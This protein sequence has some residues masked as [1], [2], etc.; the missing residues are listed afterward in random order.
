M[1]ANPYPNSFTRLRDFL[2]IFL[3]SLIPSRKLLEKFRAQ[4]GKPGN[5]EEGHPERWF[6]LNPP[7]AAHVDQKTWDD[8]EFPKIFRLID[9]TASPIGAQVLHRQLREYLDDPAD[10]DQRHRIHQQLRDDPALRERLYHCLAPITDASHAWVVDTLY[11]KV[12]EPPKHRMAISLWGAASLLVMVVT[13]TGLL[14][15][16]LWLAMIP[17]NL[18][19]LYHYSRPRLHEIETINGCMHLMDAAEKLCATAG[20]LPLQTQ[21]RNEAGAR[22]QIR[23]AQRYRR[24]IHWIPEFMSPWLNLLFLLEL[25]VHLWSMQRFYQVRQHLRRSFELVG[26]IDAAISMASALAMFPQHCQPKIGNAMELEVIDGRHPL[27]SEGVANSLSLADRSALIIGSNMAGKTT[28]IKMLAINAILG[29]TQGFCLAHQATLPATPVMAVIHGDHS[30]ESG[31][32]RYFAEIEA[33]RGFLQSSSRH[34]G[35]LF[36]IDEPFSGTNTAERIA[37]SCAVLQSLARNSLVLVTSHDVELQ[38]MLE[39]DY[40]LFHFQE[41]PD[42][43]GYFDYRLRPGAA[44]ERNA[45]RL[46]ARV[47]FP[48]EVVQSAREGMTQ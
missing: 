5:K 27:L 34:A 32:S 30:V 15:P 28:F 38:D 41:N 48:N 11:A 29:R 25:I 23:R 43:E 3:D 36:V 44:T 6:K 24:L 10:L 45:I 40:S 2:G 31:K 1:A 39:A 33:I 17:V 18:I 4:W 35:G 14:Q 7:E 12:P 46:L 8:L 19:V 20:D 26:G 22:E 42:I 47:G 9:N 16:W 13:L 21:L 37:I